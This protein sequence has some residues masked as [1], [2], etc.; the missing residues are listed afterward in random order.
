MTLVLAFETQ[1]QY[2]AIRGGKGV[3]M[4]E[5]RWSHCKIKGFI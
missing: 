5:E 4:K 3:C 1:K 2:W